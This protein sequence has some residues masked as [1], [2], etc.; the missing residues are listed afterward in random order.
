MQAD[1]SHYVSR[2]RS[3]CPADDRTL[4]KEIFL[5][6]ADGDGAPL[7]SQCPTLRANNGEDVAWTVS[8]PPGRGEANATGLA[9][10][11]RNSAPPSSPSPPRM[12]P[13]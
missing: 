8:H 11:P 7:Q 4:P 2:G 3:S 1:L 6:P 13:A 9:K 12:S 5:P 10:S